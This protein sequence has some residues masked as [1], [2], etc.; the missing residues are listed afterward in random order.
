MPKICST[1]NPRIKI[2][3]IHRALPL[4]TMPISL[5]IWHVLLSPFPY[6]MFGL[7][8]SSHFIYHFTVLLKERCFHRAHLPRAWQLWTRLVYPVKAVRW[9]I[10]G[11]N[12]ST[13]GLRVLSMP[14]YLAS[15][16]GLEIN[17]EPQGG[18]KGCPHPHTHTHTTES[19]FPSF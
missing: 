12:E 7:T 4:P 9:V 5:S 14:V 16:G 13:W 11:V 17:N 10:A 18:W 15:E 2:R 19:L 1:Q 8:T 3:L 6:L